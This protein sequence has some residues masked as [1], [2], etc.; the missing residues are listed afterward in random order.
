M[1]LKRFK[2]PFIF[3]VGERKWFDDDNSPIVEKVGWRKAE[4][5][6]TK[7]TDRNITHKK[8]VTKNQF[9]EKDQ[10]ISGLKRTSK[11]K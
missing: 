8:K 11:K 6:G 4:V 3:R 7:K 2:N 10:G 9:T 1:S 5:G